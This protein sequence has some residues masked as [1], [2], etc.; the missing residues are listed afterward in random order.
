MKYAGKGLEILAFPSNDFRQE[1]GRDSEIRAFVSNHFPELAASG[2]GF[3][4]P[5]GEGFTLFAK[6]HVSRRRDK[7]VALH[8]VYANLVL[9]MPSEGDVEHNF[10]KYLVNKQGIAVN[11]FTKKQDPMTFEKEIT[12]LLEES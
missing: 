1:P 9:Q 5:N 6:A 2:R 4:E 12:A 3:G 8:P 7:S 11:R 10:F